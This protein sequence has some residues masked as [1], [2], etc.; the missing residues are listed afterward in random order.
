LKN[1]FERMF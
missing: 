1:Y